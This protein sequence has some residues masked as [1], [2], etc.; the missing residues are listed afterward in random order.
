[1]S[2]NS[3]F[4][5]L[6][7]SLN[8]LVFS[9]A[10]PNPLAISITAS[11]VTFLAASAAVS[12]ASLASLALLLTCSVNLLNASLAAVL[13]PVNS[14]NN[15]SALFENTSSPCSLAFLAAFC[16]FVKKS[17]TVLSTPGNK[18]NS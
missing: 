1:M 17:V 4:N 8:F 15:P 7:S 5:S 18:S 10:L 12:D 14:P 11:P 13:P 2:S 3:S 6:N 16:T 9:P